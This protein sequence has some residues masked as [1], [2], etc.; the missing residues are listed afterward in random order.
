MRFR[1]LSLSFA[2][3]FFFMW[4]MFQTWAKKGHQHKAH[5]HGE[6]KIQLVYENGQGRWELVVPMEALVGFEHAPRNDK[7]KAQWE[8][9][10]GEFRKAP[11][12][13]L[14]DLCQIKDQKDHVEHQG[15]HSEFMQ[16][17]DFQCPEPLKERHLTLNWEQLP[18]R[19]RV[20][21]LEILSGDKAQTYEI[22][23]T[24]KVAF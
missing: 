16:M 1:H 24:Q 2:M 22:R 13:Q 15:S 23:Q 6:I 20:V 14:P 11:F 5:S 12:L 9:G 7:Q 4:P 21:H 17:V 8:K 3:V 19:V 10:L 18:K